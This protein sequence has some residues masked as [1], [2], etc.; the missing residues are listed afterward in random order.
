VSK[1][2]LFQ[3]LR[4]FEDAQFISLLENRNGGATSQK[5]VYLVDNGLFAPLRS[6]SPDSGKLFENQIFRD[7]DRTGR[8]FHFLKQSNGDT[9]LLS[10][11]WRYKPVTN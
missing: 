11:I 3:Y 7:L 5:K 4:Y 10:E 6:L 8:Q 1:D 2:T 9:D